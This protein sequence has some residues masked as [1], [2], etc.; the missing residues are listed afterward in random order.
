MAVIVV[1][2]CA[3][4]MRGDEPFSSEAVINHLNAVI[5]LYRDST[6]KVRGV[7]LPTEAM[8]MG[9]FQALCAQAVRLSFQAAR[10][11]AILINAERPHN[12]NQA[13]PSQI[14]QQDLRPLLA[15]VSAR[16]AKNQNQI[17]SMDR[18]INASAGKKRA[19]LIRQRDRLKG[20]IDLDS[21]L[22]GAL[23]KMASVETSENSKEGLE[24]R[25]DQLA[26][27]IPEIFGGVNPEK[28]SSKNPQNSIPVYSGLIGQTISL[29]HY[30]ESIHEIDQL[31]IESIRV[32]DIAGQL[33]NP[34]RAEL[35]ATIRHGRDLADQVARSTSVQ[36]TPVPTRDDFDKLTDRF[37]RVAAAAVPLAQEITILEQIN[38]NLHECRESLITNS[39]HVV[40]ALA[41]YLILIIGALVL[42]LILSEVWRRVTFRYV[43]DTRRRRQFLI[44]RRFAVGIS[45]A[46][47]LILGFVS[48]FSS[49]ATFAGFLTAGIAVGLQ[50]VLLSVAAYFFLI[51]R[52]GIRVGDRITIAEVTGD[53]VDFGLVRFSLLELAG[54]G[55][56]LHPTG[57]L[58]VFPN[59]VLFQ[60]TTPLYKQIPGTECIW[61]EVAMELN[62][63]GNFILAEQ[64]ILDAVNSVF[65]KYSE[66][67]KRQYERVQKRL[68]LKVATPAP[69]SQIR[70]GDRGLEF[71]VRYPVPIRDV[72]EVDDQV[73]RS[74]LSTIDHEPGLKDLVTS[75][76]KIRAAVKS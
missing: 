54:T 65:S 14:G 68:D 45:V 32:R 48:E 40:Q 12:A 41:F 66:G 67:I 37:N 73:S 20:E 26:H 58:V 56:D 51:G 35:S 62:P 57:R 23:Q 15:T 55:V 30:V 6:T 64:K 47:V 69:V 50:A 11:E 39:R 59:S 22:Q 4:P 70:L 17:D 60:A 71:V 8:Y 34:L 9:T 76:P 75:L 29:Y 44:L 46:I 18:R 63:A 74:I 38:S 24:G 5:A 13:G 2:S 53:V 10:A 36:N 21:A 49:L 1:L 52:Y 72:S 42:I 31:S 61:H 25:I 3:P 16:I 33:R 19:E 28:Q 27:S 7:G 43:H